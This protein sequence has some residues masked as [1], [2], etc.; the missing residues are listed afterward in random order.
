MIETSEDNPIVLSAPII[1]L[2]HSKMVTFPRKWGL[3]INEGDVLTLKVRCAD[4]EERY[5]TQAI[6][7]R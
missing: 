3:D 1:K 5:S 4:G 6:K 7:V 2:G